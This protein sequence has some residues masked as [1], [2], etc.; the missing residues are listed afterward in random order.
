MSSRK[1]ITWALTLIAIGIASPLL[2]QQKGQWVPGQFGLNAGVIPDPGI[3]YANLALNYSAGR[4]NNSDG[5]QISGVTGNYHFW[6]DENIAYFV[7][8]HKFL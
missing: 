8:S 6:V 3:T 5:N 7:P 2:A 4:L 1:P